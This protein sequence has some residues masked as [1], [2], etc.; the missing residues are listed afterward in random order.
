MRGSSPSEVRPAPRLPR[1]ERARGARKKSRTPP[2]SSSLP[3][4]DQRATARASPR[5]NRAEILNCGPLTSLPRPPPRR[6]GLILA[7]GLEG[8]GALG[9]SVSVLRGWRA[10]KQ[11][12]EARAGALRAQRASVQVR[13]PLALDPP[14][15]RRRDPPPPTRPPANALRPVRVRRTDPRRTAR[16]PPRSPPRPARGLETR[17][18]PS[19]APTRP[20]R[21]V[22]RA[23]LTPN[24]P[25][26]LRPRHSFRPAQR[27]DATGP[28]GLDVAAAQLAGPHGRDVTPRAS[29]PRHVPVPPRCDDGEPAT[30]S[31]RP[32]ARSNAPRSNRIFCA[33]FFPPL[34]KRARVRLSLAAREGG[35]SSDFRS[36]TSSSL[37][38]PRAS[39]PTCAGTES[40]LARNGAGSEPVPALPLG[41][42]ES[43]HVLYLNR[44]AYQPLCN[45]LKRLGITCVFVAAKLTEVSAP[46]AHEFAEAAE[47]STFTRS[48]L[49]LAERALLRELE[50]YTHDPTPSSFASAFLSATLPAPSGGARRRSTRSGAPQGPGGT[51]A[52]RTRSRRWWTTFSRPR[53]CRT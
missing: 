45:K 24:T 46:S 23:G 41:P 4:C 21:V 6:A 39:P 40:F 34:F 7:T 31:C 27:D 29:V 3:H 38:H 51:R 44:G 13:E 43:G 50:Y 52:W 5:L 33:S 48:Q 35:G 2:C 19:I 12:E 14:P 11:R 25:S 53:R 10:T 17:A 47:V 20:R 30:A 32:R 22:A 37:R 49:L 15:S 16:R 1:A 28:R 26:L 42:L 18:V 8:V 9:G 36:L